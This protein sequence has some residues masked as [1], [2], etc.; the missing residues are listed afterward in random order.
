MMNKTRVVLVVTMGT[1][2]MAATE[3]PP[4][5]PSTCGGIQGLTCALG[6]Y[7]DLG[8]GACGVADAQ[9]T[10]VD[11]PEVC[12]D[13]Y[14][15]V[16]GCDG[17]SY[18]TACDAAAS[19]VNV[20]HSGMCPGQPCGT[21][22]GGG[23]AEGEYCA[24]DEGVCQNPDQGGFC[25]PIPVECPL[26]ESFA[27]VCGCDGNTYD[28][29]CAAAMKGVNVVKA[30]ACEKKCGKFEGG[31]CGPE[32]YC[33]VGVGVCAHAGL[34]GVCKP[35]PTSCLDIDTTFAPVKQVC[36]CD[37]RNY[38]SLCRAQMNGTTLANN[39][40]ICTGCGRNDNDKC[41]AGQYCYTLPTCAVPGICAMVPDAC[42]TAPADKYCACSGSDYP[43]MCSVFREGFDVAYRGS[44]G[45][46]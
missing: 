29:S 35:R 2:L 41:P 26:M 9:G 39:S 12:M 10:C 27:P 31:D 17:I 4:I 34:V 11:K 21:I 19:G 16:C 33:D 36:G 43:D 44:C 22:A 1:L 13:Q 28:N 23:C 18:S 15:P 25:K 3:C 5:A 7:C 30:G 14:A 42:A 45:G 20:D 32:E 37:G 40:G 24:M 46:S 8:V 6:Q 38:D